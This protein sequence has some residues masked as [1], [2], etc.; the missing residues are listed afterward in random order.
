MPGK[1]TDF[2]S[3]LSEAAEKPSTGERR[4]Q[5]I[6]LPKGM[7]AAWYGASDHQISRVGTL[8]MGG[9][10]IC[11][12]APP[13]VGTKLKLAF[14]VPGGEIQAEGIVRNVEAG[15]GMGIQFTRLGPKDRVLLQ[16]LMTRLLR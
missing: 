7:W 2:A 4:Y 10:F 8:S 16:R 13:P 12:P 15:K 6:A 1:T 9:I 5:R 3:T 14:E 11:A